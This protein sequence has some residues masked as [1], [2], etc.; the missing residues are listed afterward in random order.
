MKS[1][2]KVGAKVYISLEIT[3]VGSAHLL[4]TKDR[5]TAACSL[6]QARR[7]ACVSW[8]VSTGVMQIYFIRSANVLHYFFSLFMPEICC[9]ENFLPGIKHSFSKRCEACIKKVML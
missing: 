3:N 5:K 1:K 6:A 2:T 8:Q 9:Y 7:S 4:H